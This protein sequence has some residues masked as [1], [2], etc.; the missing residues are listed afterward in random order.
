[1]RR[2]C[3]RIK[4]HGVDSRK[5]FEKAVR[6]FAGFR[7][8]GRED[9]NMREPF[10]IQVSEEEIKKEREKARVLR[11]SRWWKQ[12]LARGICHYCQRRFPPAALSM[13]HVVPLI[14]GGKTTRG[15]WSRLVRSATVRKSTSSPWSGKHTCKIP[16]GKNEVWASLQAG[17]RICS[18][19]PT[20]MSFTSSL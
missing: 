14:R 15:T 20:T 16:S 8:G 1:M 17:W 19:M 11:Q 4:I 12:R 10:M 13:D 18:L 7:V 5:K 6:S 9:G 3:R 2:G